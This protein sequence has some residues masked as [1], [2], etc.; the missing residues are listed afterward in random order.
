MRK[1]AI[2]LAVI[3][4]MAGQ[5]V[6]DVSAQ[7]ASAPRSAKEAIKMSQDGGQYLFVLFYDKQDG[8]LDSV[9]SAIDSFKQKR[10]EKIL[11]YESLTTS[12][13]DPEM[14]AQYRIDRAPLP[15]LMVFGPNG[16]V[17]GGFPGGNV[18]EEKLTRSF[19]PEVVMGVLKA[20]QNNKLAIVVLAN[21]S[22]KFASQARKTAFDLSLDKRFSGS[23]E[24]IEADP[25]DP[26]NKVFM[27][28][29]NAKLNT[30]EA[31]IVLIAPPNSV[32]GV[33]RG[34]VS[35]SSIINSISKASSAC[36]GGKCGPGGCS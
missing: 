30:G 21:N 10:N 3:G 14:V 16:A 31:S 19:V 15:A 17:L 23:A 22:A 27:D 18:T 13:N 2:V 28:S 9:R 24:V 33:Y 11:V 7:Q 1:I 29:V 25:A 32:L 20:V 26:R 4:L 5:V 36:G 6:P 34:N 35:K 8:Q 12:N